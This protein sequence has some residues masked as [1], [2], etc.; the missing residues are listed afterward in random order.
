[1]GR[2]LDTQE[3][4]EKCVQAFGG[5]KWKKDSGRLRCTCE[6]GGRN[7]MVGYGLDLPGLEYR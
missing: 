6:V 7:V 3:G 2:A 5:E 4:K 1:M